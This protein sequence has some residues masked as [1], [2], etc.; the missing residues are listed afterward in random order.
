MT[1]ETEQ[2]LKDEV[3]SFVTTFIAMM[4]LFESAVLGSLWRGDLD[5]TTLMVLGGAC[6]RSAIKALIALLAPQFT[7]TIIPTRAAEVITEEPIIKLANLP[8]KEQ[9]EA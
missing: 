4:V 1:I 6:L 8:N 5:T 3:K 2:F 7:K 9:D